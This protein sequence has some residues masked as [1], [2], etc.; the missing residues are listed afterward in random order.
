M[1]RLRIGVLCARHISPSVFPPSKPRTEGVLEA[2]EGEIGK[3]DRGLGS[4]EEND[5][6]DD[7]G[8]G[9]FQGNLTRAK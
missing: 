4:R 8:R 7:E 6:G 9:G 5:R 1:S 2:T 3:Q